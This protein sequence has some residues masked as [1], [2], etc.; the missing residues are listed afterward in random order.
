M[1]GV[2]M[3]VC[4]RQTYN[5]NVRTSRGNQADERAFIPTNTKGTVSTSIPC[6]KY[7]GV[8]KTDNVTLTAGSTERSEGARGR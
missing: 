7:E 4:L 1:A 3:V 5:T 6:Q 2:N 8:G